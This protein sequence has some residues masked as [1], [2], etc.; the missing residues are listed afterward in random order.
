MD[1]YL[2]LAGASGCGKSFIKNSLLSMAPGYFVNIRQHTTRPRREKEGK[3]AYEFVDAEE[4]EKV[5]NG[6]MGRCQIGNYTYGS[7]PL[8]SYETRT[9][10]IVL[11]DEGLTDFMAYAIKANAIYTSVGI[12]LPLEDA[13]KI[14]GKERSEE[15]IRKE[16]SIYDRVEHI[17]QNDFENN[18]LQSIL[19]QFKLIHEALEYK[20]KSICKFEEFDDYRK[21]CKC[22]SSFCS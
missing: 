13:V 2:I 7:S 14:R 21:E 11:N 17:Y 1:K 10:I 19:A 8:S 16:Y 5:K 4:F 15:Y 18:S 20:S 9:G 12:Y 22:G 6:L 3:D